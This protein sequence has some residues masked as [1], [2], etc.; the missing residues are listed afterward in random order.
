MIKKV[1]ITSKGLTDRFNHLG[2]RAFARRC[3]FHI[4]KKGILDPRIP[5]FCMFDCSMTVWHSKT[6]TVWQSDCQTAWQ[7]DYESPHQHQHPPATTGLGPVDPWSQ[8]AGYLILVGDPPGVFQGGQEV[9][10]IDRHTHR[11]RNRQSDK[12]VSKILLSLAFL[13]KTLLLPNKG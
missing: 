7:S 8:L 10:Q 1:D 9:R 3:L 12:K 11:Q 4:S 5:T 2:M 6:L 13:G